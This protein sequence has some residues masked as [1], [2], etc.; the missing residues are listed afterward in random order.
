MVFFYILLHDCTAVRRCLWWWRRFVGFRQ[1]R[2]MPQKVIPKFLDGGR[3]DHVPHKTGHTRPLHE[4]VAK[5]VLSHEIYE[6]TG[7]SARF[8][9]GASNGFEFGLCEISAQE[10][11]TESFFGVQVF[12]HSFA[13]ILE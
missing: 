13:I 1:C 6:T 11:D 3:K 5:F 8:A 10:W 4:I 7:W 2:G 12:Q 9:H